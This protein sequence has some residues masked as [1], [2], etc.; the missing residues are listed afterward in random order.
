MDVKD[1]RVEN[2]DEAWI[3][4]YRAAIKDAPVEEPR[5]AKTLDTLRSFRTKL[6]SHMKQVLLTI[7]KPELLAMPKAIGTKPIS[8][9]VREPEQELKAS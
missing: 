4:K 2:V 5:F 9:P 8:L 1:S 3:L 7:R 6:L